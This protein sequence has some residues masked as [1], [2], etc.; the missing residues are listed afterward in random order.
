MV[1]LIRSHIGY[2]QDL[3]G[4]IAADARFELAAPVPLSLVCFRY[5]GSDDQNRRLLDKINATG[6]AFLSHTVL[7]GKFVLRLAYG[8]MRTTSEDVDVVWRC[9]QAQAAE[10]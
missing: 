4:R 2:A 8:N 5:R 6:L 7:N 3:A 10:L 1:G 9:I